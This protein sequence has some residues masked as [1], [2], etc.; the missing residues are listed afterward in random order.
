M[1]MGNTVNNLR[2][3]DTG[4]RHLTSHCVSRRQIETRTDVKQ[5]GMAVI[6]IGDLQ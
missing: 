5:G 6:E 4:V 1:F 3:G 2:D